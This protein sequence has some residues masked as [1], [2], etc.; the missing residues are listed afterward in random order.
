M[1]LARPACTVVLSSTGSSVEG[2]VRTEMP[3][4]T[5][6]QRQSLVIAS[7][8]TAQT[9]TSL[10]LLPSLHLATWQEA[11]LAPEHAN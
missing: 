8:P 1:W 2:R 11:S 7:A 6:W 9:Q 4:Y 3:I 5:T 10:S